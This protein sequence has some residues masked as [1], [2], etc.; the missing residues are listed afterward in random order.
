MTDGEWGLLAA[1]AMAG[2]PR[3]Y[4]WIGKRLGFL[5]QITIEGAWILENGGED[6]AE[7][8]DAAD[9]HGETGDH[10]AAVDV[11]GLAV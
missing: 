8:D 1:L 2:R 11:D 4:V 10:A 7:T 6:F 3:R 5:A 9:N